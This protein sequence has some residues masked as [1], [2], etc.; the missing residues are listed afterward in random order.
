MSETESAAHQAA[1]FSFGLCLPNF[2]IGA[3]REGIE[4]SVDA[5]E[6]L[7]WT[8]VWTTDHVLPD[9]SPRAQDYASIFDAIA[10]LAYV[11]GRNQRVGIGLSVLVVPM[12][13]AVE[14]AKTLASVDNLSGGRLIIGAGIGWSTIEYGNAGLPDRFAVRGAYLDEAIRVWRHLWS[15]SRQPFR[16]RFQSFEDYRF[17]PLPARGAEVPIV[18]GGGAAA[19]LR[20][21]G[22]LADGYHSSRVSPTAYAAAAAAV[23]AAAHEAGKPEPILQARCVVTFDQPAE[24][25][26]ALAGSTEQMLADI[27]AYRKLG[28]SHVCVDLR[29]TDP[30]RVVA[31]ME[32]FDREVVR[33]A[34]A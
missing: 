25:P 9:T 18:I 21:A 1:G 24:G 32:R 16:G 14:Q 33:P 13:N 26:Y 31:A 34:L 27:A 22:A 15:G 29:E 17:G 20:R 28:V 6:R 10:T 23:R 2:R 5:V 11:A 30:D 4:A 19:A 12:R 3:S 8:T 7:G